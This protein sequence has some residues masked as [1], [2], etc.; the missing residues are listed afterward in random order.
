MDI[1]E[2]SR[3]EIMLYSKMSPRLY[4]TVMEEMVT[5][6]F[7]WHPDWRWGCNLVTML[8]R[9]IFVWIGKNVAVSHVNEAIKQC[10]PKDEK[11]TRW[12]IYTSIIVV[13]AAP[14]NK[15]GLFMKLSL[16]IVHLFCKFKCQKVTGV[17][18]ISFITSIR[19]ATIR[20][21]EVQEKMWS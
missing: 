20:V 11:Y 16:T 9:H 4:R 7:S 1:G 3:K 21:A 18:S 12:K 2:S 17:N 6:M 8:W 15:S 10:C 14:G 5:S 13:A 19:R